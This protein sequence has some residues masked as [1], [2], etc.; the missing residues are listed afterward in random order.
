MSGLRERQKEQRKEA[1][2]LAAMSLFEKNGYAA[3]TVEAIA[4][5]ASVS[6]P[7][8]FNYFGSK[9]EILFALAVRADRLAL[10][11]ALQDI[12]AMTNMVDSMCHINSLVVRH[13]LKML[14]LAIW[15]EICNTP[16]GSVS[17]GYAAVT[18]RLTQE[19]AK[20]LRVAQAEGRLTT[21]HDAQ[22]IAEFLND[23]SSL[24]FTKLVNQDVP[25]LESYDQ[26]IRQAF[27]L[28]FNGLHP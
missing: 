17:Q 15:R 24:M 10:N 11:Q 1:I 25:D 22:F 23:Y 7:T 5:K 6:T 13:E 8:V 14:P 19:T 12:P 3:T 27:E 4:D 9:Q 18:K 26:H 2:L 16:T 21:R 20:Q 28:I